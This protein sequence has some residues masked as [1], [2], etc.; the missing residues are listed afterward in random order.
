MSENIVDTIRE[1]IDEEGLEHILKTSM[2]GYT[3]KSVA[4]YTA[5]LKKQQQNMID[6][7]NSYFQAVLEEKDKMTLENQRLLTKLEKT[8]HDYRAL[9]EAIITYKLED[10]DYTLDDV[11]TFQCTIE[12]L[13]KKLEE[14]GSELNL[15]QQKCAQNDSMM[16]VKEDEIKQGKQ[17]IKLAQ[18]ML[19]DEKTNTNNERKKVSALA[20]EVSKLQEEIRFLKAITEEGNVAKLNSRIAE[21]S[22]TVSKY[23]ETVENKNQHIDI[24][25]EKIQTLSQQN[26]GLSAHVD[27]LSETVEGLNVQNRSL[28]ATNT[29]LEEKLREELEKSLELFNKVSEETVQK[30]IVSKKLDEANYQLS[31]KEIEHKQR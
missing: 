21:L 18:E 10:S 22:E 24:L 13:E 25:E 12:A 14:L 7:F 29:S 5:I 31:L 27:K 9:S 16:A 15:S 1:R 23:E 8:D 4:E 2:G 20:S 3:K 26:E 30:L 17:E 11:K 28:L 6:H 19:F